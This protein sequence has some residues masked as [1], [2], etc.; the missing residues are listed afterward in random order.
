MSGRN[1]SLHTASGKLHCAGRLRFLAISVNNT[2]REPTGLMRLIAQAIRNVGSH[3][4]IS[5]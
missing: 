3:A 4:N 2:L 5:F 1:P